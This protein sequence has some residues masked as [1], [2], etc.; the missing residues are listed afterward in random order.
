MTSDNTIRVSLRLK[1]DVHHA[2]TMVAATKGIEPAAFMQDILEQAV[3]DHLPEE[4]QRE[5]KDTKLLFA[6]AQEHAKQVFSEGGF[7]EH[8][9][10]TVI[11]KLMTVPE[12]R[13]LYE[14]LIGTDAYTDGAPK[15]TPLNMYLGWFIKNAISAQPLLDE[16]GKPRRAFV[17]NEPIKSYTLLTAA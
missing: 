7:T 14:K 16:S 9:T 15:K 2:L 10:L 12:T 11:Q 4:R 6:L 5:L 8:F 13:N 3:I 1:N 17:K